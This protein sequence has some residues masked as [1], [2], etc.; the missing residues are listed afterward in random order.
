MVSENGTEFR[1]K[2][3]VA[4]NFAPALLDFIEA[5]DRYHQVDAVYGKRRSDAV[6]GGR[7]SNGIPDVSWE[8][9][10]AYNARCKRDGIRFNYLMNPMCLS[11]RDAVTEEHRKLMHFVDHLCSLGIE[12]VTVNSPFLCEL[13]KRQFPQMKVT[14]G[15]YAMIGTIQQARQWVELGAD[16]IT[17]MQHWNRDFTALR[18]L[19]TILKPHGT[20]IRLIANNACLHDC[21]FAMNHGAT[22]SHSSSSD[23][24]C[25]GKC[26]IDY[27]IVS[28]YRKKVL[29]PVHLLTSEWIRPEDMHYYSD[30]CY[31]TG[32][33]NLIMK[34]VDRTRNV[35][36]MRRL[37]TAYF[38]E[39]Y[40]GNLL[41][42]MNWLDGGK[43]SAAKM[44]M[45]P[46]LES[47]K[48]KK[49]DLLSANAYM[50]FMDASFMYLDNNQLDGF[51]DHFLHSFHCR[52]KICWT[53]N[54]PP[55]HPD[56]AYCCHCYSWMKKAVSCTSEIKRDRWKRNADFLH[57]SME[58][59]RIFCMTNKK[60]KKDE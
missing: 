3:D 47:V 13:I 2:Y 42:L 19:M 51:L 21:P 16:E 34:L 59:S 35:A 23:A 58:T 60:G 31:E 46:F 12:W 6:G 26:L 48:E 32:N 40:D 14:V 28:C 15:L 33:Y 54:T 37:L 1:M 7:S 43:F 29:H 41:D 44:D 4:S 52:E 57:D 53:E 22:V 8:E 30:L 49:L 9:I 11:N 17:L 10:E 20:S 45:T 50:K 38:N 25:C 39:R 36:F 18:N 24:H 27:N 56:P 5:E 55:E